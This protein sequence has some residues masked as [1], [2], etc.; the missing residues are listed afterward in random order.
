M[1]CAACLSN[2]NII[3]HKATHI[4]VWKRQPFALI[5][6]KLNRPWEESKLL[7][8]LKQALSEFKS[9]CRFLGL[10]IAGI[11]EAVSILTATSIAIAV[12]THTIQTAQCV[13]Q[14]AYNVT[15]EFYLQ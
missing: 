8:F 6:V 9:P 4:F 5:P 11:V 1:H 14:V 3:Y 12:I 7:N 15:L 10:L 2:Y 13:D